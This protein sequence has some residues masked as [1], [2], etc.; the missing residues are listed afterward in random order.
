MYPK[1]KKKKTCS[2]TTKKSC[3]MWPKTK[4]NGGGPASSTCGSWCDA[5]PSN[6]AATPG[7]VVD[8]VTCHVLTAMIACSLHHGPHAGVAHLGSAVKTGTP[9]GVSHLSSL[10]RSR[11]LASKRWTSWKLETSYFGVCLVITWNFALK[12]LGWKPESP[13]GQQN[14]AIFRVDFYPW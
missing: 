5:I 13:K 3:S 4:K 7:V 9:P 2:W 12:K 11:G 6:H 1:N 10:Q 14:L 8:Q